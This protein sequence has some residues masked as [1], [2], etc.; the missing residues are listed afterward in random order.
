MK[1]SIDLR[2]TH[3]SPALRRACR[4]TLDGE[5]ARH[6]VVRQAGSLRVEG[7]GDV[8]LTRRGDL[9]D[10]VIG[11]GAALRLAAGDHVAVSAWRGGQ[12]AAWHWQPDAPAAGALQRWGVALLR[13]L[14]AALEAWAARARSAAA[15]ASRAHGCIHAGDSIAASGA[16][17]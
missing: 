12:V 8:W 6:W 1:A 4:G 10:H 9:A 16:L 15:S 5:Q 11:A 13:G 2:Q 17:K 14:A 3:Q 7:G